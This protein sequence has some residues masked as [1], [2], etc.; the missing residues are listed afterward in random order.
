MD[1]QEKK[2]RAAER[3]LHF[4][5]D[6][7]VLG[8]GTGSTAAEFVKLVGEQVA[9]GLRVSGVPTSEATAQLARSLA[10]PLVTLDDQPSVDLTVDG[11]DE[12]DHELRLIKGGGGALLREKITAAASEM[13]VIIADD[14]KHVATLGKF[15]LPVEIVP[16]GARATLAMM[17]AM[18]ADA[19]AEGDMVIRQSRDGKPFVSDGGHWIVD[20]AFD[21]IEEPEYL[22]ELLPFVPGVVEH[23]LFLGLA[24]VAIVAGDDGV[25]ELSQQG[26]S[27]GV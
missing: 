18:A 26:L 25:L 17:K 4:V 13:V 24:D 3:A 15:P 19:G 1:A 8:L 2:F 7:M 12:L 10:I 16:F 23:G 27:D 5:K 14:S 9:Q 11:A 22:A 20:C 6:G 21:V